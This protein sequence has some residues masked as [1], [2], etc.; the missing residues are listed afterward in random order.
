MN[1]DAVKRSARARSYLY[2]SASGGV[3]E[4]LGSASTSLSARVSEVVLG[5]SSS[6]ARPEMEIVYGE[7]TLGSDTPA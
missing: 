2:Y 1:I 7:K 6:A 3:E 4:P 5:I